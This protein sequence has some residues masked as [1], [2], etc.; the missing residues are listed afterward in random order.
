MYVSHV[1][2]GIATDQVEYK[3]VHHM[4]QTEW[5]TT[6]QLACPCHIYF[7][8]DETMKHE[9]DSNSPALLGYKV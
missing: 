3:N 8:G 4:L 7:D 2:I 9:Q 5:N 1:H 6:V